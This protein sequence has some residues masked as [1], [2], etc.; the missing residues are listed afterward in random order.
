MGAAA[1][2][3][4]INDVLGFR[5]SASFRRDGGWVDRAGYSLTPPTDPTS[6]ALQTP[7]LGRVGETDANW[8]ETITFRAALKWAVNDAVSVTPSFYYSAAAHQ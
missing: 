5:I 3:P 8:Q 6:F 7:V 2:G 4:I 1:G